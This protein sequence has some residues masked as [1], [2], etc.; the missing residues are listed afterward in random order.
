MKITPEQVEY[1]ARLGRLRLD[2]AEKKKYQHQLDDILKSVELEVSTDDVVPM[3]GTQ[4]LY[5]P[6]REDLVRPSLSVEGALSNA[7]REPA[8]RSGSPGSSSSGLGRSQCATWFFGAKVWQRAQRHNVDRSA[9]RRGTS[10]EAARGSWYL[11]VIHISKVL[12][13]GGPP[14]RG[15]SR[16]A[17]RDPGQV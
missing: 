14:D 5:T 13:D 3:A 9:V 8:H 11:Q 1:V 6:L 17:I 15:L 10:F 2:E 4:E 16:T 12:M 7:P